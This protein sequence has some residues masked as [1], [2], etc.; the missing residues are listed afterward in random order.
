MYHSCE[1][2]VAGSPDALRD[3]A[4]RMD[5]VNEVVIQSLAARTSLSEDM[6]RGWFASGREGW[7]NGLDA[8]A[9]GLASGYATEE[10][11]PAPQMPPEDTEERGWKYAAV[12]AIAKHIQEIAAMAEEKKIEAEEEKTPVAE[13]EE[14]VV[15]EVVKELK[16]DEKKEDGIQEPVAEGEDEDEIAAL[17][18]ENEELKKQ[19]DALKA[20]CDKLTSGLRAPANATAPKKNFAALVREIPT[21]IS[22]NEYARRFTA[23]KKEHKAEYDAYMAS[24]K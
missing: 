9:C 16:D 20:T 11:L 7:L 23:L 2:L 13:G 15:K 8:L 6:V 18:A 12:A 5:I 14:D 10:I 1:G 3:S 4:D 17:K 22:A 24:H 21:D 19:L